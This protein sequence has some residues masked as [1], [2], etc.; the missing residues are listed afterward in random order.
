MGGRVGVR[1][2][3]GLLNKDSSQIHTHEQKSANE[4]QREDPRVVGD[5]C[6][7]FRSQKIAPAAPEKERW[8]GNGRAS[9]E[10]HRNLL[11]D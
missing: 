2:G 5:A 1:A 6:R 3:A 9:K 10:A 4:G 8:H 7:H 11:N